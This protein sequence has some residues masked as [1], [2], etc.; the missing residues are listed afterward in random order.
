M[1][2][3]TWRVE[4]RPTRSLD[5]RGGVH[6]EYAVVADD[7]ELARVRGMA[8]DGELARVRGEEA[9]RLM[10]AAP[11]LFEAASYLAAHDGDPDSGLCQAT[12]EEAWSM[13]EMAIE[14]AEG[15]DD[16]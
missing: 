11:E 7:G 4:A 2:G 6:M 14:K 12:Y 13:L 9:A 8:D 5:G 15:R 1:S 10:A 3:E 16:S